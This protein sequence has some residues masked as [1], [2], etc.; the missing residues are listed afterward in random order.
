MDYIYTTFTKK[1]MH[2]LISGASGLIGTALVSRLKTQG[3]RI[4]I[5][6]TKRKTQN[7]STNLKTFFWN[8]EQAYIDTE[9]L[10]GVDVVISL[11]GSNVAQ[12]W[13]K[14]N[15][16]SIFDS[17]VL[18]TRLLVDTI[19]SMEEH[20]VKHFIS[21]SAIGLYPAHQTEKYT[22]TY[23][24]KAQG[25]LGTVVQAWE[26]EVDKAAEVVPHVSKIRIGLVLAQ[27]GGALPR[28]A[29]PTAL[30][31]G[32]WFGTGHQWQSWI[33]IDDLVG[34]FLFVLN[35]PGCYN[36]VAPQPV[37][38]KELIKAIAKSYHK[39]QFLP[40]IPSGVIKL[41]L[42]QMSQVLLDSVY[43]SSQKIESK[44]FNFSFTTIDQALADLIPLSRKK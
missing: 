34:M 1:K 41:F 37:T 29:T 31:L 18:G 20:Q 25:F 12:R 10:I 24:A 40:G 19:K 36:G 30:G 43:A 27:A 26:A 42:G 13:T 28:L 4:S 14:R 9:A 16:Q 44:G 3:H 6:S 23:A 38:Q 21:A 11:A 8:P 33:H 17:R 35:H 5:L 22:E 15:K 32:T 2:V 39:P 7:L